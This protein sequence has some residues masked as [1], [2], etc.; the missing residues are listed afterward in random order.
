[1]NNTFIG[2]IDVA[3]KVNF[4]IIDNLKLKDK[5]KVKLF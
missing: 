3:N 1:M 4:F 2:I 5:S